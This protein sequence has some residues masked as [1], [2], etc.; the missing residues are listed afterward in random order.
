MMTSKFGFVYE[1]SDASKNVT[2]LC[3]CGFVDD[4][5]APYGLGLKLEAKNGKNKDKNDPQEFSYKFFKANPPTSER[6]TLE[7]QE[8]F[9]KTLE[10]YKFQF[11]FTS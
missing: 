1:V 9:I 4:N 10:Y 2:R 8:I 11:K 7:E 3:W 6:I 5:Y